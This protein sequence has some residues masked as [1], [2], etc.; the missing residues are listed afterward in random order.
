M[1][2]EYYDEAYITSVTCFSS[3]VIITQH[4]LDPSKIPLGNHGIGA[5]DHSFFSDPDPHGL[6][7]AG[8]R[9][10]RAGPKIRFAIAL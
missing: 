2:S 9:W 7:H 4:C 8:P 6:L 5:V 1:V 10:G 3:E